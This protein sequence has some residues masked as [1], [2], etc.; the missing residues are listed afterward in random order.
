VI[1][2]VGAAILRDG[3]VLAAHR[4][5]LG[6]ELPGGKVEPG[7]TP[8]EALTREVHEELGCAVEV[9]DWLSGESA[10]RPGLVLRVATARLVTGEPVATEHDELRWVGPDL[11]D[12][13]WLPA[14]RPFL[15]GVSRLLAGA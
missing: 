10:I 13:D 11:T 7:E 2:V 6:W 12:L 14:D 9:I 8:A 5:G 1:V 15:A 3:L 4:P